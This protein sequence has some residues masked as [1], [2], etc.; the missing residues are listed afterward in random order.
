[1]DKILE[2][3]G[4]LEEISSRYPPPLTA[5]LVANENVIGELISMVSSSNQSCDVG[6]GSL[7]TEGS[8]LLARKASFNANRICAN[9]VLSIMIVVPSNA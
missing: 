2:I 3:L 8:S 6:S 7:A 9:R 5:M 1:M 4:L